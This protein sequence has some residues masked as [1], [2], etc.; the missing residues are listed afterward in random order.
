M[1]TT[2]PAPVFRLDEARTA[3]PSFQKSP[4][5]EATTSRA[6]K[7]TPTIEPTSRENH[8]SDVTVVSDIK[9]LH[10]EDGQRVRH[11]LHVE[12]NGAGLHERT[13]RPIHGDAK[14]SGRRR[15]ARADAGAG[16]RDRLWTVPAAVRDG[17]RPGPRPGRR[18]R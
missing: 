14:R 5:I 3:R 4:T 18:R 6:P 8:D 16:E 1:L 12:G 11:L 9:K 13:G 17:E 7:N 10:D 2:S 15:A